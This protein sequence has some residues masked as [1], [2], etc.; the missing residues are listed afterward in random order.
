MPPQGLV[1]FAD[2][3]EAASRIEGVALRTPL[4]AFPELSEAVG[5][6]VRLKCENLQRAG[7]FKARGAANFVAQ[8]SPEELERGVITYS[9]GNHGQALALAA[10]S[11]GV[12]AVVV[13]PTTAPAVKLEGAKRL[14]AEVVLEGT[15]SAHRLHRAEEIAAEEGLTMAPPFEHPHV[16]A[17]QGTVGREIAQ[18]WPEV[19]LVLAPIGGGGLVSGIALAIKAMLPDVKIFGVEAAGAPTMRAALDAGRPVDLPS[20]D[21]IA[22]GLKP[23]RV[24]DLT[25]QHAQALLDDVVLVSDEKI[26]EAAALLLGRRKLVTEFSGAAPVGALLEGTVKSEGLNVAAVLSGG[27]LDSSHMTELGESVT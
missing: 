6:E 12:R 15:T 7:S 11:M 10:R 16:I 1:T 2:V 21:T 17:G 25:F 3:E 26:R 19:Q 27:N 8:L 14:G 18:E 13:M 4:L 9:S 24:G 20:V 22:D 5:G 23:V